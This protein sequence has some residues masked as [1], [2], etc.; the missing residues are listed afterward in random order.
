MKKIPSSYFLYGAAGLAVVALIAL[1]ATNRVTSSAP[2][3]YDGFAQ[4]LADK[5]VKM[6]GAWWCPHCKAQKELF[7]TAFKK[8][9]YVECSPNQ[10]K[11]MSQECKDAGIKGYPTWVLADSSQLS[12]EQTFDTLAAKSGCAL[13]GVDSAVAPVTDAS[14]K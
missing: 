12:G 10:S 7:G 6:Y 8:I 3:D 13:P 9:D 4:C 2:S 11:D 14:T 1:I 5:G